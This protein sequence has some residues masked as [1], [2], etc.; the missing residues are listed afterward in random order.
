MA[1]EGVFHE[2]IVVKDGVE[3]KDMQV[4]KP[5]K[6]DRCE[7]KLKLGEKIV[8]KGEGNEW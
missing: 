8:I 7:V 3:S 5:K 4:R 2:T 6:N 1:A